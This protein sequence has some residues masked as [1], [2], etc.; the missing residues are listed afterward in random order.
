MD[1]HANS[2]ADIRDS[3][4]RVASVLSWLIVTVV[5]VGMKLFS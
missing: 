5:Y 2:G 1:N 4:N 3:C